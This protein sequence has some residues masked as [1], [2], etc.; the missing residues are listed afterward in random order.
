MDLWKLIGASYVPRRSD[1]IVGSLGK[2]V[3]ARG[4][5]SSKTATSG[6]ASRDN[7]AQLASYAAQITILNAEV[8]FG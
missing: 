4:A 1:L 2:G 5:H 3:G 7:V 8:V 6:A